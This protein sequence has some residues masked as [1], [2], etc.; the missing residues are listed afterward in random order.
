MI[1][2]DHMILINAE[3]IQHH[4]RILEEDLTRFQQQQQQQ[5]LCRLYSG[6]SIVRVCSWNVNSV[7]V[8]LPHVLAL[9]G[10][11]NPDVL[12]LQET[13]CM[14]VQFPNTF[15]DLKYVVEV[16][17]QQRYNGVAIIAKNAI[18]NL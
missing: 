4:P 15:H 5:H 14:D 6:D 17:G 1:L 7:K 3:F 11:Y 12:F 2:Q 16:K 9:L 10:K 18:R 8:C 13:K